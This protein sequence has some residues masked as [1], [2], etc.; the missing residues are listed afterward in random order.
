L[1]NPK[2]GDHHSGD[3]KT[4]GRIILKRSSR[5]CVVIMWTGFVWLRQ[6]PLVGSCEHGNE[7]SVP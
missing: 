4:D 3:K 6:D 7:P 1:E 2:R 5:K